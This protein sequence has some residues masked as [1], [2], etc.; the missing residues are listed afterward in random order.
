MADAQKAPVAVRFI[1]RAI[2]K[3][4]FKVIRKAFFRS[5]LR[6]RRHLAVGEP[7]IMVANHA[8]SLGPVSVITTVPVKAYPWVTH[9]VTD[10]RTVAKRIQ[11]YFLEQELH[12]RPPVSEFLGRA[13]GRICAG[14]MKDIGAIP[15]YRKSRKM[16]STFQL[17]LR[18]L[19]EGK[20]IL[21]FAED[22]MRPLNEAICEFGTGFIH[23]AKLY[24]RKTR[25]AIQFIPI[26]VN[27]KGRGI[28]V[29]APIR[30][31]PTN[32]F[33]LEKERL[34]RELESSVSMLYRELEEGL[35]LEA[36]PGLR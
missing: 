26:A 34:K 32:P 13:I 30:F 9:E 15:V 1:D 20:N 36:A 19:E 10:L 3:A 2:R 11:A 27:K 17:S 14:L 4:F 8:G 28:L 35:G 31:D 7:V 5:K 18:L 21:V 33:P 12:L 6:G 25:K 23:L 16:A 24:Y 29:G 22:S